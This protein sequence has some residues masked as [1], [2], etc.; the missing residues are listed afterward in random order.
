MSKGTASMGKKSGKTSHIRCRRCGKHSYHV[1]DKVC[2][3]CGFGKSSKQRSY[4]WQK[5]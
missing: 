1:R 5:K 4:S 3:S 2:S